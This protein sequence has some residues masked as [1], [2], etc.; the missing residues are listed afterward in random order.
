MILGSGAVQVLRGVVLVTAPLPYS[1][2]LPKDWEDPRLGKV[3][4][5][6]VLPFP[7]GLQNM[8]QRPL[9]NS[10]SGDQSE[11][12]QWE[13]ANSCFFLSHSVYGRGRSSCSPCL[14]QTWWPW[15]LESIEAFPHISAPPDPWEL[16]SW[17][18]VYKNLFSQEKLFWDWLLL[19]PTSVLFTHIPDS[20]WFLF[21]PWLQRILLKWYSNPCWD[22]SPAWVVMQERVTWG[23]SCMKMVWL[24]PCRVTLLSSKRWRTE[25]EGLQV[26]LSLGEWQLVDCSGSLKRGGV[27]MK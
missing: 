1:S 2:C 26:T 17:R 8:G 15:S 6:P 14:P 27:W 9:P 23:K 20:F 16:L 7:Q 25:P 5:V 13:A 19:L 11:R 22:T 18:K 12:S 4:A 10:H 3:R 24:S 21:S